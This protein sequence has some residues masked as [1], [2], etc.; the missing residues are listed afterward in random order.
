MFII[1]R[2]RGGDTKKKV[3]AKFQAE[4]ESRPGGVNCI[5]GNKNLE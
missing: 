4:T 5:R 3:E 1:K 2:P